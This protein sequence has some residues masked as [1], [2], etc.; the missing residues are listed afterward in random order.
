MAH[1]S[2]TLHCRYINACAYFILFFCTGPPQTSSTTAPPLVSNR[3]ATTSI[4]MTTTQKLGVL[5]ASKT[6]PHEDIDTLLD[7]TSLTR[8]KIQRSR[9]L[10]AVPSPFT[11]HV[12]MATKAF[13]Q[14]SKTINVTSSVT[15][16]TSV[17]M[18]TTTSTVTATKES[19]KV[20][21]NVISSVPTST[22]T[23]MIS[24]SV[25]YSG[26]VVTGST[27]LLLSLVYV[28]TSVDAT[29]H[30]SLCA[31]CYMY[32]SSQWVLVSHHLQQKHNN[33]RS[34]ITAFLDHSD[35]LNCSLKYPL[36]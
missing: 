24:S 16:M 4:V 31:K 29:A 22:V 17:A 32:S 11:T 36:I 25:V 10:S 7:C 18:T 1:T 19:N 8:S 20:V 33:I 35:N 30:S 2:V 3:H 14:I 34:E 12:T 23:P 15:M 13:T 26:K 27:S 21:T 5:S 6:V 28:S 9:P